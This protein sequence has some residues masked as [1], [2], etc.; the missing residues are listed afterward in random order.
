MMPF[1]RS[2]FGSPALAA[3]TLLPILAIPVLMGSF[4]TLKMLMPLARDFS[5]DDWLAAAGELMFLGYQP[6]QFTHAVFGGAISPT[7]S[8]SSIRCGSRCCSPPS[9]SIRCWRR[10]TSAPASSS[11]S[12]PAHGC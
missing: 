11:P 9:S 8:T 1:L 12:Q 3:G 6:W 2:R 4:G 7:L 5:W 10:A